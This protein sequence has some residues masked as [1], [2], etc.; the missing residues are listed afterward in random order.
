MVR[1]EQGIHRIVAGPA[2][3]KELSASVRSRMILELNFGSKA[4]RCS[5]LVLLSLF[6]LG[7]AYVA[8]SHFII[9][10]LSDEGVITT[11]ST[12]ATAA[13]YFSQ[14]A[15][16]QSRL[17]T[18]ELAESMGEEA[19]LQQAETAALNAVRRSPWS[20]DNHLLLASVR[21]LQGDMD[22]AE[23]SM[24][25]AV[26]FAP[27]YPQVHWHLANLLARQGK[28]DEALSEFQAAITLDST[29]RFLP[30]AIDVGWTISEGNLDKLRA[31]VGRKPKNVLTLAQYL[32]NQSRITDA[33]A[34]FKSIERP[35]LLT[36]PDA[37]GFLDTV[38]SQGQL[39]LARDLWGYLVAEERA[40][41]TQLLINGSFERAYD[42]KWP[43]FAWKIS[44][45]KFANSVID[46][47]IAHTGTHSLRISFAGKDTTVLDREISQTVVVKPNTRY[48]LEC[49]A[50]TEKFVT[51][52]GVRI[53]VSDFASSAP[54][55]S[56]NPILA[57]SND[58]QTHTLDFVTPATS[59]A[60]ILSIKRTPRFSYDEPTSGKVWFDDF[61][62]REKTQ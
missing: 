26:K 1:H 27:H 48:G 12:L 28:V 62:L 49:F 20:S 36:M 31:M 11:R 54:F 10:T 17:A 22:G 35:V 37:T 55:A 33:A 16:L 21:N 45:S 14:S 23:S 40:A 34:L 13:A 8:I 53:V 57:G 2:N 38:I 24:R 32:L 44:Q 59:R 47:T 29:A 60:I 52:E 6:C 41:T 39:E 9:S 61:S 58:W 4:A 30:G 15:Q 50:R 3:N 25:T 51:T 56:S 5:A 19:A 18:V 7:F 43:Q 46:S 42:P